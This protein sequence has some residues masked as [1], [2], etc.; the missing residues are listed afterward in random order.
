M[1]ASTG[2]LAAVRI[3]CVRVH[4]CKEFGPPSASVGGC[5]SVRTSVRRVVTARWK[6]KEFRTHGTS[7]QVSEGVDGPRDPSRVGGRAADRSYRPRFGDRAGVVAPSGPPG[8]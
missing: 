5:S 6:G 1:T 8:G 2:M 3:L 7:E 4:L